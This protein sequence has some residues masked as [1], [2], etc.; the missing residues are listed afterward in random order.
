[1]K[2]GSELNDRS[3]LKWKNYNLD[4]N[5]IKQ[6]IKKA[7][8]HSSSNQNSVLSNSSDY[9]VTTSSSA[10]DSIYKE[11]RQR[12]L[13]HDLYVTF[14]SQ[15][16]FVSLFV[17]SKY[18]EISRRELQ[19]KKQLDA[20]INSI[21]Y[22][23]NNN[24]NGN[25]VYIRMQTRKLI[26]IKSEL[27]D[28]SVNLQDLSRFV[29]LQKIALRKLFKK[30]LKYSNYPHKQELVEKI[31][32]VSLEGNPDS[33]V[34]LDL[35]DAVMELT[36]MFDVLNNYFPNGAILSQ[37]EITQLQKQKQEDQRNIRNDNNNQISTTSTSNS[38]TTTEGIINKPRQTSVVTLDS[39]QLP[40]GPNDNLANKIVYSK[41]V[42][43]DL[44]SQKKGPVVQRY[45]VHKD[46]LNELNLLLSSH[47]KLITDD[48]G[49][50]EG[51]DTHNGLS[52]IGHQQQNLE[53]QQQQRQNQLQQQ[54]NST[55][56]QTFSLKKTKSNTDLVQSE[57]LTTLSQKIS[58]QRQQQPQ[59]S[60]LN[61]LHHV[62]DDTEETFRPYTHVVSLWLNNLSNP[63]YSYT[64]NII[65]NDLY[66]NKQEVGQIAIHDNLHSASPPLLVAPVG[67][68]RQF[69]FTNITDELSRNIF[70]FNSNQKS[71][72]ESTT[73]VNEFK[74]KIFNKWKLTGM[75]GNPKMA[76]LSFDWCINKKVLPLAKVRYNRTRFISVNSAIDSKNI[77]QKIDCYITLDEQIETVKV[78]NT[79][80]A[81]PIWNA[82]D[83]KNKLSFPH[84]ILE[85]RYESPLKR[86][87]DEVV[88]L[89]KSHLVYH[90]NDLNFSLNNY[91]LMQYYQDNLSD[92]CILEYVAPWFDRLLNGT[93][94][95]KLPEL[96]KRPRRSTNGGSFASGNDL[97]TTSNGTVPTG[98]I[99]PRGILLNREEV[100]P[101]KPKIRYWNEFDDGSEGEDNTGFYVDDDEYGSYDSNTNLLSFFGLLTPERVEEI[102]E[103]SNRLANSIN[104]YNVLK[105]LNFFKQK[106]DS[107]YNNDYSVFVNGQRRKTHFYHSQ[108]HGADNYDEN[109]D[110]FPTNQT[111]TGNRAF[112]NSESDTDLSDMNNI[113]PNGSNSQNYGSVSHNLN[114]FNMN[115]Q[116]EQ[117]PT[118]RNNR[119]SSIVHGDT[120]PN[121][122]ITQM[123]HDT[124]ISFLYLSIIV[125]S[126][127]STGVGVGV[128]S[129][130]LNNG[131]NDGAPAQGLV[132]VLFFAFMSL[133]FSL[134]LSIIG[135]CLLM[136]RYNP[137]P[138]YH[139]F[140][141][142]GVFLLVTTFLVISICIFL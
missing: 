6:L 112:S 115:T 4:Y 1:M 99:N 59:Q 93:D 60:N 51:S 38:T 66:E 139:H 28:I 116:L 9:T 22:S 128:I 90:V 33:F 134:I 83:E 8:S 124:V 56:S 65:G 34:N 123:H 11:R 92:D 12:Q 113:P 10:Q 70:E 87:T 138:M 78:E 40:A 118:F 135:V 32:N 13:L 73:P 67:G 77:N 105:K 31:T 81:S 121:E 55:N 125:L 19:I 114:G 111:N 110:L 17:N 53:Q 91:L 48:D 103:F 24:L 76:Q 41:S 18:G 120:K 62:I 107:V 72:S 142:W 141:I 26:V 119:L 37:D 94:I 43:F 101:V 2:F 46:N 79:G 98:N 42:T 80:T 82:Q 47:F 85:I 102:L 75:L 23:N 86:L 58:H 35:N 97:E 16:E 30:F 129:S 64:K 63:V 122:L 109:S 95:R 104:K 49:L 88:I 84:A 137:A 96:N 126:C 45:W 3:I 100:G 25:P 20:F 61:H 39:L 44:I 127:L 108:L 71:N 15:I 131:L 133:F 36:L 21:Y 132:L 136:A 54:K 50:I 14:K 130:L 7:T 89:M 117:Q 57:Q 27:N 74:E 68:L 140:L 69:T 52:H 29:M 5:Q 106:N